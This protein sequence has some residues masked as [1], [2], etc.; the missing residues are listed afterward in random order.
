MG[1]TKGQSR[2]ILVDTI[3]GV[4]D[5]VYGDLI[6]PDIDAERNTE[7]PYICVIDNEQNFEPNQRMVSDYSLTI[8]GFVQGDAED[9]IEKRDIL[10]DKVFW[11]LLNEK[12]LKIRIEN[13]NNR[14]IY[15]PW[16]LEAGVYFPYAAFRMEVKL[17]YIKR[18]PNV[19]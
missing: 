6:L 19:S 9:L 13:I 16:G 10:E 2:K 5:N 1:L 12:T 18:D 4:C 3:K 11:A 8:I 15:Q 7:F 17:P 14:N